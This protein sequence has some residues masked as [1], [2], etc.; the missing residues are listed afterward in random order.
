M[1]QLINLLFVVLFLTSC[2]VN[3]NNKQSEIDPEK[4]IK[5]SLAV[6]DV[7]LT[8]MGIKLGDPI[9][10]A[11]NIG[12]ENKDFYLKRIDDNLLKGNVCLDYVDRNGEKASRYYEKCP[13]V[14]VNE[15]DGRVASIFLMFK[16]PKLRNFFLDTFNDRYYKAERIKTNRSRGNA[17]EEVYFWDFKDTKITLTE[18]S[19]TDDDQLHKLD[20]TVLVK[21]EYKSLA[22]KWDSMKAL[23]DS[24]QAAEKEMEIKSQREKASSQI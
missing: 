11:E 21:Y 9:S 10:V 24:I 6:T 23:S 2:N 22:E 1:K 14:E 13:D 15:I 4:S 18:L 19:L 7:P 5:D 12:L 16:S 3:Y 20:I 8:F 17:L